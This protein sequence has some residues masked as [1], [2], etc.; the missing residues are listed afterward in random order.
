MQK[1]PKGER[2][3]CA[4]CGEWHAPH[5]PDNGTMVPVCPSCWSKMNINSK[6]FLIGQMIQASS[7]EALSNV[8]LRGIDGAIADMVRQRLEDRGSDWN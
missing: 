7:I 4:C 1:G 5:C 2:H 6:A 8:I 3:L